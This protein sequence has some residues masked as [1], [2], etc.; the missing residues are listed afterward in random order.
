MNPYTRCKIF[1]VLPIIILVLLYKPT[2]AQINSNIAGQNDKGQRSE[3][4]VNNEIWGFENQDFGAWQALVDLQY[5]ISTTGTITDNHSFTGNFSANIES[6]NDASVGA[7]INDSAELAV[8]DTLSAHIFID[9]ANLEE[10]EM[11]QIFFL[12]GPSWDFI[13]TDY[14]NSNLAADTWNEL[15]LVAPEGIGNTQRIGLQFIGKNKTESSM[16]FID[17]ISIKAY[18]P[19]IVEPE[20]TWGFENQV[21]GEW[22]PLVDLQ[23]DINTVGEISNEQASSG[24]YSAKI[25]V[26]ND[27]NVGALV[28]NTTS[29]G[30]FDTLK[31]NVFIPSSELNKIETVQIFFLHGPS[32]DFISTDYARSNL[33]ADTWSELI[34]V[35]PEGIANTQRIGIQFIGKEASE[36]SYLYIDAISIEEYIPEVYEPEGTWGFENQVFGEWT[37]LVDLQFDVNTIGEIESNQVYSGNCSAKIQVADN[38]KVGAL[39]NNTFEVLEADSLQAKIFI[40]SSEYDNIE[41]VQIFLL[42][43]NNWNFVSTDYSIEALAADVWNDLLLVIPEN[44]GNTQRIGIQFIGKEISETSFVYLDA[45][46]V[47]NK[48][49]DTSTNLSDGPQLFELN[50]NY[51]NPFNPTTNISFSIRNRGHVKLEVFNMLGQNVATLIDA[52]RMEGKH[53]VT[54]DA[55]NLSSG[56]YLYRLTTDSFVRTMKMNLIK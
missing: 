31:A 27:A 39:V 12:H 15:I 24:L 34:L 20:G 47:S 53:N 30:V 17:D 26:Q 28:N 22:T 11:V 7:L 14:V 48:K 6:G 42:H 18:V 10:I 54:F 40:P 8:F 1:S 41:T 2:F 23:F 29:I 36:T 51:P 56:V 5:D 43:G 37:P 46:S 45:I 21:F 19:E 25:T 16:I 50:Q 52:P 38:A 55:R 32:W 44:I 9:S 49:T 35:A 13:S 4:K 33:T 3:S